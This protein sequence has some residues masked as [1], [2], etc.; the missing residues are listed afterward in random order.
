MTS[1]LAER[2]VDVFEE[3][4]DEILAE[5]EVLEMPKFAVEWIEQMTD[6]NVTGGK[7]NRGLSVV[8]TAMIIQGGDFPAEELKRFMG[9]GWCIEWARL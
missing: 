2:F 7:M 8:E 4:K 1:N 3:V 6:Y 9:L 5:L